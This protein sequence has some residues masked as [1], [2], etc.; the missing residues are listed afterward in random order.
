MN[1][2]VMASGVLWLGLPIVEHIAVTETPFD[3]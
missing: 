2:R 3:G 1:G